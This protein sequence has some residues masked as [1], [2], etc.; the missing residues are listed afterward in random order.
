MNR[1][2]MEER[3]GRMLP[4]L[5]RKAAVPA[6]IVALACSGCAHTER[7][8]HTQTPA[9]Q[10][11]S[12][13]AIAMFNTCT[14]PKFPPADL[15][16]NHQGTVKIDYLVNEEGKAVD[17]RILQSTGYPAMDEAARSAL[18]KCRFK[19]AHQDGRPVAKWTEVLY[20]WKI[21]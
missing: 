9:N 13:I 1:I 11:N 3:G 16:A 12:S 18:L 21:D 15:R 8:A 17:S 4:T 2:V 5:R 6:L 20:I 7:P 14:R 10:E 19:P